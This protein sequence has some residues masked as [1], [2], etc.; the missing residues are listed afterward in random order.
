MEINLENTFTLTKLTEYLN[1][2][3]GQKKTEKPFNIVDVEGY[4]KRKKLPNY[5]G[6]D[7]IEKIKNENLGKLYRLTKKI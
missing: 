1:I 7:I 6:G 2:K 4:I 3:F 5:L